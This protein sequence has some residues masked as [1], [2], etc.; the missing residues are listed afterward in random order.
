MLCCC[1]CSCYRYLSVYVLY[2]PETTHSTTLLRLHLYCVPVF[3]CTAFTVL[4]MRRYRHRHQVFIDRQCQILKSEKTTEI[5]IQSVFKNTT[6]DSAEATKLWRIDSQGERERMGESERVLETLLKS[7]I[8]RFY[9]L[10]I[11]CAD[12]RRFVLQLTYFHTQI[13][14]NDWNDTHTKAGYT[15]MSSTSVR[16]TVVMCQLS[17]RKLSSDPSPHNNMQRNILLDFLGVI[18]WLPAQ[19]RWWKTEARSL[20]NCIE[21]H[22]LNCIE[23]GSGIFI[24]FKNGFSS[25]A[26]ATPH[27][28]ESCLFSLSLPFRGTKRSLNFMIVRDFGNYVFFLFSFSRLRSSPF[29]RLAEQNTF[30]GAQIN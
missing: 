22:T 4:C 7:N 24:F 26:A 13:M 8:D 10:R 6:A 5:S 9:F 28:G 1:C 21:L 3:V 2:V 18:E 23:F 19:Q 20:K 25:H 17:V 30:G 29:S 27:N 14:E 16:S 15:R 12:V 11:G